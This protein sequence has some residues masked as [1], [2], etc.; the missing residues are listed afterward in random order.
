MQVLDEA[1]D[2]H[3]HG[4]VAQRNRVDR[5]PAEVVDH[6]DQAQQVLLDGD[7]E[8]ITVFEVDG[9]CQMVS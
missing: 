3:G 8:G 7:V 9:D 2:L 1:A 4:G 6:R 5:K